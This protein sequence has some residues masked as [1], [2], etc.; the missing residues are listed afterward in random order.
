MKRASVCTY[1]IYELGAYLTDM[2]DEYEKDGDEGLIE[3]WLIDKYDIKFEQLETV[4]SLLLP[5]IA[6]STSPLTNKGYVGFA[7]RARG[8]YLVKMEG[9]L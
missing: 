6:T 9:Q 2:V 7:D 3:E 1:D 8:I 5:M 4:V